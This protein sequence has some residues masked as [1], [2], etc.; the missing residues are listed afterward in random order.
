MAYV[1]ARSAT[2]PNLGYESSRRKLSAACLRNFKPSSLN[3]EKSKAKFAAEGAAS[4]HSGSVARD[5]LGYSHDMIPT[6]DRA[7]SAITTSFPPIVT[8]PILI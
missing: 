1:T 6:L 4:K 8:S 2:A 5:D 3:L 7:R